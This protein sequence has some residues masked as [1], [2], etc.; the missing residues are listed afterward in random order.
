[1]FYSWGGA[2]DDCLEVYFV[3]LVVKGNY[4]CLVIVSIF[5]E[6]EGAKRWGDALKSS[7]GVA[8]QAAK[9]YNFYGEVGFSLCN[10]VGLKL[11]FMS[12]W[13]L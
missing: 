3:G 11:Y 6:F 5:M 8:M 1:M 7:F 10:T 9:G 2:S 4:W 12:Y 13:V